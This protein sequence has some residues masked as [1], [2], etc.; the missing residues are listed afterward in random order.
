MMRLSSR[1]PVIGSPVIQEIAG[2]TLLVGNESMQRDDDV[3]RSATKIDANVPIETANNKDSRAAQ[4][5]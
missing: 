5:A 3:A 4:K 1:L 2:K